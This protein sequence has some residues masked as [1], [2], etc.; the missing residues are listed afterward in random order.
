MIHA[1]TP[2]LLK[3]NDRRRK[4]HT[5][6]FT[7]HRNVI[8]RTY[9]TIPKLPSHTRNLYTLILETLA[10]QHKQMLT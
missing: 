8:L 2:T 3:L 10:T 4:T 1:S 5:Q 6:H 9:M 7:V